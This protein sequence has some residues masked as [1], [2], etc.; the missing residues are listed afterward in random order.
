MITSS[1]NGR[2]INQRST[3]R[4]AGNVDSECTSD[5]ISGDT[6]ALHHFHL[7]NC[8]FWSLNCGACSARLLHMHPISNIHMNYVVGQSV[9]RE[10]TWHAIHFRFYRYV[11]SST[12]RKHEPL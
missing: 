12:T 10:E 6:I 11:E 8:T 7:Q 2:T 9:R 5:V 3:I 4:N 1:Q